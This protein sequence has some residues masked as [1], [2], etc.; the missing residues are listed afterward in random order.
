MCLK[1]FGLAPRPEML[2]GTRTVGKHMSL[3]LHWS[4][5]VFQMIFQAMHSMFTATCLF[6]RKHVSATHVLQVVRKAHSMHIPLPPP[7]LQLT[8]PGLNAGVPL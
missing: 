7:F 1:Q 8:L 3:M 6:L 5:V 2:A 4:F